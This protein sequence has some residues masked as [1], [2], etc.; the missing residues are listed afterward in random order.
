MRETGQESKVILNLEFP[1]DN[2]L[3]DHSTL[4]EIIREV[5]NEVMSEN[6]QVITIKE[7]AEFLKVSIPTVRA[8]IASNEIPYFQ[9]GQVIRLNK[10]DILDWF[11]KEKDS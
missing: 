4:K 7:T 2:F 6:N 1:A 8:W 5:V 9:R 11:R 10:V 3:L